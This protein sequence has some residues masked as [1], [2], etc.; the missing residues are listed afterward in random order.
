MELL[1]S[2]IAYSRISPLQS[3]ESNGMVWYSRVSLPLDTV[4]VIS[5][6]GDPEL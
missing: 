3:V 4:L 2:I 5:E 1:E 6:T